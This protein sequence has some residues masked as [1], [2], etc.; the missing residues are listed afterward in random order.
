MPTL[1][2]EIEYD[3][4]SLVGSMITKVGYADGCMVIECGNLELKIGSDTPL[5]FLVKEYTVQ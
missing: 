5:W 1:R 3:A 2:E 4:A